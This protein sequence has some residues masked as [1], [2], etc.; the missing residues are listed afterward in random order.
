MVDD[1]DK[2]RTKRQTIESGE[3]RS[4]STNAGRG[5]RE[6]PRVDLPS[7]ARCSFDVCSVCLLSF[8]F[9]QKRFYETHCSSHNGL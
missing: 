6:K 8:S 3:K 5:F 4:K 9:Y 7:A 2:A 1:D